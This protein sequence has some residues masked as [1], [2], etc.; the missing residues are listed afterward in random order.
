MK[1]VIKTGGKQYV[2]SKGDRLT[3]DKIDGEPGS[4]L[5]L[6][7]ILL[8]L[9]GENQKVGTPLVSGA[10]VSATILGQEKAKKIIVYK[11]KRRKGYHKKQGHRQRVTEISIDDIVA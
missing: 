6:N 8:V 10:K 11:Y 1:A 2:V 5:E 4:K 9:D 7:E 3:I